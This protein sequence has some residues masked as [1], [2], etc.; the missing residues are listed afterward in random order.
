MEWFWESVSWGFPV[1]DPFLPLV[2]GEEAI[3]VVKV[4]PP[5][6]GDRCEISK[7]LSV[8]FAEGRFTKGGLLGLSVDIIPEAVGHLI[9]PGHEVVSLRIVFGHELKDIPG[10]GGPADEAVSRIGFRDNVRDV[11]HG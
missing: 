1:V 2:H 6:V 5:A 3:L 10:H 9:I 11:E 8:V 7:K 4:E